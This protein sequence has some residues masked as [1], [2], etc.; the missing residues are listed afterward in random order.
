MTESSEA[1]RQLQ[2]WGHGVSI[3]SRTDAAVFECTDVSRRRIPGRRQTRSST[4]GQLVVPAR[5]M[6][7]VGRRSFHV[8]VF[9][10]RNFLPSEIQSAPS[11]TIFRYRLEAFLFRRSCTDLL[12]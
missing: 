5:S 1:N 3:P 9:S 4:S 12:V 7:T 6:S 10:L 2:T 8:A 11:F